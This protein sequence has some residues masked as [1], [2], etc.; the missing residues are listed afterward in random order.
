M[1]EYFCHESIYVAIC[2]T[3]ILEMI[4]ILYIVISTVDHAYKCHA[5]IYYS[6]ESAGHSYAM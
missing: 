5:C 6:Y 2:Y 4:T 1:Q 3:N